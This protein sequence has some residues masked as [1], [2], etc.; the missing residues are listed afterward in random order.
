MPCMRL[1]ASPCV[2]QITVRLS[3]EELADV[4]R[5]RGLVPREPFVRDVLRDRVAA[6]VAIESEALRLAGSEPAP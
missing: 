4:D 2:K 3:D 5:V 1:I 6:R